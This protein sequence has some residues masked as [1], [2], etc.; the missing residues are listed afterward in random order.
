[1]IDLDQRFDSL[2]AMPTDS[3]LADMEGAV[4]IAETGLTPEE[5]AES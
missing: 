3:R 2:R 4:M 5:A 1:M